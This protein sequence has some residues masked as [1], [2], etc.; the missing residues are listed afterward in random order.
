MNTNILIVGGGLSGLS[1]A[2]S[3]EQQ[4][5]DY[6]LVE[7]RSRWGGR[8][9][10]VKS[11][12]DQLDS[13]HDLGPSWIWPGQPRIAKLVK[14]LNIQ[15]F[16]QYAE[17][18]L[19]YEDELGTVRRDLA[20]STM[21]G[22]YRIDGGVSTVIEALF[23]QLDSKRA[24]LSHTVESIEERNNSYKVKIH[25]PGGF[26]EFT[27]NKVILCMPPRIVAEKITFSPKLPQNTAAAMNS[28]P[29]WM[30]GHAKVTAVYDKPFWRNQGLSGDGISRKG[31]L[32]EIHDVS[33]INNETGA[34]FGFVGIP[35]GSP[36]RQKQT[37]IQKTKQQLANMFGREAGDPVDVII[38]DWAEDEFTATQSDQVIGGHPQYGMPHPISTLS[39]KGLLFASTEMATEFGGFIEGALEAA[40][41]ALLKLTT[42]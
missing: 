34:L 13:R 18:N 29:T 8:I 24:Y 35:S 3:L 10:S 16:P 22:S 6:L 11:E 25:T 2:S 4:K 31:P 17:G 19:V 30:A 12:N 21:A 41:S 1:I 42:K 36:L 32:A 5:A 26:K 27:A 9:L 28:I 14:M 20:Y 15:L 37:L 39:E 38:K 23:S 33:P 7:A 40:E